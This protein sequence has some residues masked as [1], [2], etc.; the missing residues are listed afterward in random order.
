MTFEHFFYEDYVL[1]EFTKEE[2]IYIS[3]NGD[4]PFQQINFSKDDEDFANARQEARMENTMEK[5]NANESKWDPKDLSE[6]CK[7]SLDEMIQSYWERPE[8]QTFDD[9]FHTNLNLQK[10]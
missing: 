6:A 8:W 10:E 7:V 5:P 3:I 4:I 1:D 2:F 9:F